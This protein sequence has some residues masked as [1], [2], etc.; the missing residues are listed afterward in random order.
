LFSC[1]LSV[2]QSS[3]TPFGRSNQPTTKKFICGITIS[4]SSF[5]FLP[6][7]AATH[8]Y[9]NIRSPFHPSFTHLSQ[10]TQKYD[11]DDEDDD[12]D[13]DSTFDDDEDDVEQDEE[14]DDEVS[15]CGRRA[16]I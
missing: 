1:T 9:F 13:Q 4:V 5:V 8:P 12:D 3:R 14:E 6:S 15:V 16:L 10:G 11:Q 7:Y 2:V